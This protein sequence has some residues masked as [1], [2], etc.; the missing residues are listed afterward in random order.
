MTVS[1]SYH[2]P[3][4][5]QFG[6]G[7]VSNLATKLPGDRLLLVTTPGMTR[8]GAVARIKELSG[9]KI[10]EV[11]DG[12]TPNP[13]MIALDETAQRY[14]NG[15]F[16]GLVAFGGGSAIDTGKILGVLLG[17]PESFS[18]SAHF[19]EKR[20]VPEVPGLP[21]TAIPTTSGTGSEVTPFA[22]VWDT[23]SSKKYSLAHPRMFPLH[24]IVDPQLTLE[25]PWDVTLATGLDA[26][27]QALESIWNRNANPLTLGYAMRAA[28]LA[29]E[30]LSHGKGLME[31]EE[32][33]SNLMEASL[34]AGLAISH[35]RTALCHSM[36]YPITA[37]YGVPH[38][39]ACGMW[40]PAVLHYNSRIVA[41]LFREMENSMHIG[42]PDEFSQKIIGL[43]R[44]FQIG[45][46]INKY[47]PDF[48]TVYDL[49]PEIITEGRAKNNLRPINNTCLFNIIKMTK[50]T[51]EIN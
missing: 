21:V 9:G 16:D 41:P 19:L 42:G 29:W 2:N 27:C 3:V 44:K 17:C 18:L 6:S 51:L 5:V 36:S 48:S 20:P 30:A 14:R 34:L 31:S 24:A 33:R 13:A 1:W 25:L 45:K 50:E 4:A 15:K 43:Y 32:H 38:G 35:T 40:V 23:V 28:K 8:R 12:V 11:F 49:L 22:T 39:L 7:T 47:I 10:A 46:L 26:F 37:Y